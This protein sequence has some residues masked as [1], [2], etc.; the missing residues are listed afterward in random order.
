MSALSTCS[1]LGVITTSIAL[2]SSWDR[3]PSLFLRAA[4]GG[5]GAGWEGCVSIKLQFL[6]GVDCLR[7]LHA[8]AGVET[9]QAKRHTARAASPAQAV[10]RPQPRQQPRSPAG[11]RQQQAGRQ[12]G[13]CPPVEA[14]EDELDLLRW[15]EAGKGAGGV[16]HGAGAQPALERFQV[17]GLA[18][19]R[20]G[21]LVVAR[22]GRQVRVGP[23]AGRGRHGHVAGAGAGAGRHRRAG[24]GGRR[25]IAALPARRRGVGGP[26]APWPACR[27]GSRGCGWAGA[28]CAAQ[29]PPVLHRRLQRLLAHLAKTSGLVCR[30][31]FST[32]SKSMSTSPA[33][34]QPASSQPSAAG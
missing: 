23:V 22:A 11:S 8:A 20:A 28:H 33:G 30:N 31:F 17:A 3:Q 6:A 13:S 32:T 21:P 29:L 26:S 5:G 25:G 16:D 27:A 34:S 14:V 19:G 15:G 7:R 24:A 18:G 12:A 9:A 1:P 2:S 4:G 10:P